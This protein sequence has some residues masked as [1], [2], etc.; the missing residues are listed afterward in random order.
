MDFQHLPPTEKLRIGQDLA[1]PA[2]V[3]RVRPYRDSDIIAHML[4]P[5]LG[6]IS[7]IARHARGSRKRFPSSLD[8]FDRGTVRIVRER[9]GALG[10]KEFTPSHS[11]QKLRGDLDKLILASLLCEAFDLILQEDSAEDS[12]QTFEVLDLALNAVDEATELKGAL[13]AVYLALVS[14]TQQGGITNLGSA[15]PGTRAL[16][17]LL[18]AIEAFCEKRLMTRSSLEPILKRI[19]AG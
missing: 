15:A 5:S 8:L 9:N 4:T 3:L 13:R 17:Q 11:L 6:K 10:I 12:T 2:L 16:A 7:A 18:D 19:A 14:L 1:V